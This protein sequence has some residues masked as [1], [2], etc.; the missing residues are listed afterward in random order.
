MKKTFKDFYFLFHFFQSFL[1]LKMNQTD[2]Q[3]KIVIAADESF[4]NVTE[5]LA[6]RYVLHYQKKLHP[7]FRKKTM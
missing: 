7:N 3:K 1:V 5:A 6:E 2:K 4:R